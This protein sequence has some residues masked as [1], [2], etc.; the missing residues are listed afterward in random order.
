MKRREAI[1]TLGTG[2]AAMNGVAPPSWERFR[3]WLA[4]GQDRAHFFT[5]AEAAIARL[6]ADMV[7]PRDERSGG[8]SDAGAMEYMDFVISGGSDRGKQ[9]WRDGLKWLDDECGRR[10][11][12]PFVQCDETQRGQVIDDIAWPARAR[13]ELGPQVNFFNGVR[14][15]VS[16]AFFSSRM[17]IE[18]LRYLGGVFNP[19]WQGAPPEALRE[20][21]VS[22]EEWD[23]KYGATGGQGD[24]RTA[25]P[26]APHA[27]PRTPRPASR[28][29]R[30]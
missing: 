22:Y 17:G 21:G 6:L 10:F 29:P 24:A 26:G 30:P 14:N 19:N 9:V 28:T 16:T 15:L 4:Q 25:N 12:K 1:V 3:A 18:D 11:Q 7:I 8:A 5:E 27:A 2:A 23:R 13:Q 20:L